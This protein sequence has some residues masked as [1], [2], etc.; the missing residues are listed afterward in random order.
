MTVPPSAPGA[1]AARLDAALTAVIEHTVSPR[2]EETDR[3]GRFP[4]EAVDALA[5]CGLLGLP[6]ARGGDLAVAAR[7]VERLAGVCG[8][9]AQVLLMHYAAA[10][11]IAAHGPEKT[12]RAIADGEHLTTLALCD[13]GSRSHFWAP[14]TTAAPA[15]P[16]VHLDG[17]KN[18][19]TAAG[20]ADSYVLTSRAL[21][22]PAAM[23]LWLVPADTPGVRPAGPSDSLGLRGSASRPLAVEHAAVPATARLGEDGA[24]FAV[25]LRTALPHLLVL[26]AACCLGVMEALTTLAATHLTRTWLTHLD[27]TLSDEPVVRAQHARL[28][29]RTDT[30]RA[31]LRDTLDALRHR[32]P[33]ATLRV[34][35]VKALAVE[36]ACEVADGVT[37]LCGGSACRPETGVARRLR[38]VL[39]VRA[40]A[41]TSE[42]LY[43]FAART[44]LGLPLLDRPAPCAAA[45]V[46]DGG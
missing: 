17:R 10:A 39:A 22:D 28:R 19:V 29:L 35:Q 34:L 38:D 44:E 40:L 14:V 26:H 2:A 18:W 3:T 7:V 21:H 30:L 32:R 42:A 23:T 31:L 45:S 13:T 36:S 8:S 12:R 15:G 43:E 11:V 20:E 4:R 24:G 6:C 37:R 9:T 5:H 27:T 46:T 1:D 16:N 25:L 41:P 33:D